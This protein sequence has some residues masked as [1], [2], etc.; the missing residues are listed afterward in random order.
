MFNGNAIANAT[1]ALLTINNLQPTNAGTYSVLVSANVGRILSADALL[2]VITPVSITSSPTNVTGILGGSADFSVSAGGSPPLT[3]Q[4]TLNGTALLGATNS[5]YILDSIDF[6]NIGIYRVII[7][8]IGSAVTS[9]PA[10]LAFNPQIIV[11]NQ[12][13]AILR[14]T[15]S[16]SAQVQITSTFDTATIFY[17]LDGST[18]SVN[19]LPYNG[20]FAVAQSVTVRAIAY[21]QNL[22]SVSSY[23]VDVMF[24]QGCSATPPG[25]V[26]WWP[27][28]F[29]PT[30]ATGTNDGVLLNGA[31]YA[32]GEVGRAFS[33]TNRLAAVDLGYA[34]NLQLQNFTI[35]CWIKRSSATVITLDQNTSHDGGILSYGGN[36][37]G[38]ALYNDSSLILSKIYVSG[39]SS[40][41]KVTDTNFHHVAVT[42]TNATV[43]FY[44]DGTNA[45]TSSYDPG[46]VFTTPVNIGAI[47]DFQEESF[48]GIIDELAFYNRAL[49]SAEIQ[50]IYAAGRF[51]RC[52]PLTIIV[53]PTNSLGFVGGASTFSV[54]ALGSAPL[55]Y[56]WLFNGAAIT[57][58]TNAFLVL[59]NVQ[60]SNAGTYAVT[61][62]DGA[63][64]TQSSDAV[65]T[66][67]APV[68]ITV[69]PTNFPASLGG[70]ASFAVTA[71]GAPPLGY[72]WTFNGSNILNATNAALSVNNVAFTNLGSYSVVVTNPWSSA[73]SAPALLS[74]NPQIM[75]SNLVGSNFV[76]TNI[77]SV[78]IKITSLFSN[79]SIFY[80]LD[81]SAPDF[82]SATYTAPFTVTQ[83]VTVR[84]VAYDQNFNSILSFPVNVTLLISN[85]ITVVNIG[86]GTVT[87]NPPG[88]V[89][90]NTQTVQATAT[91]TN[92]WTFLQWTGAVPSANPVINVP[93]T[94]TQ[95][96]QAVF[97]SPVTFTPPQNGTFQFNPD[98]PAFPYGSVVEISGL[99]AAG[100]YFALWGGS[101]SGAMNP[102][103]MTLT[104]P[105]PNFTAL[106]ASLP[107]GK[108]S[109]VIVPNGNGLVA[110][111]PS[112]N[113][114]ASNT[115]VSVSAAVT[116]TNRFYYWTGDSTSSLNPLSVNLR[117]NK[118]I[119]AN[120]SG[121]KYLI[122]FL[123]PRM[124]PTN[125][126]FNLAGA[127]LQI[128]DIDVSS[129][130]L[131]WLLLKTATNTSGSIPL[132][133][134]SS[135][136]PQKFYRA[137]LH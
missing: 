12:V 19:S 95:K 14:V 7:T 21:D 59:T 36:G 44:V 117:S 18:P 40:T 62:S 65:F 23:P 1:N 77:A 118:V 73:T 111:N 86:G 99:P 128:Y 136:G 108:F 30:D 22:H 67:V 69:P 113:N 125:F 74:L 57:N 31:G 123:S 70:E 85:T 60:S 97:G 48:Y 110:V 51:G 5:S 87:L 47:G 96:I 16:H 106:F 105:N 4:W 54:A 6:S 134:I 137:T 61:V 119:T 56:Q 50:G 122:R 103:V 28:E 98:L 120:F 52:V 39:V 15:N 126:Q 109:L 26:S 32:A 116:G 9:A 13:G 80:T 43:T 37:Y 42:K 33:F 94:S 88:G 24:L 71:S 58:A 35:E 8:N 27:G 20:P 53:Q 82:G 127:P 68:V 63:S 121:G 11:N 34:T 49:E 2:I 131:D 81:G 102:Y 76:F 84:A 133:D 45:G 90:L 89:Y 3:Y 83:S 25:L 46:F 130:L 55:A 29:S 64:Q 72:Q 17:T 41:I 78:Q 66:V 101:A 115:T 114:F 93:M 91:P 100:Y 135:N 112:G 10:R 132:S 107:P 124:T 79:A 129:N 38:F 92:G 104:N 75:V